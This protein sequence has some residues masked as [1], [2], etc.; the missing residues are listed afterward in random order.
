VNF[1][2]FSDT[3]FNRSKQKTEGGAEKTVLTPSGP[4]HCLIRVKT[5]KKKFRAIANQADSIGAFQSKFSSIIRKEL[6]G[7]KKK[8]KKKKKKPTDKKSGKKGNSS[9]AQHAPKQ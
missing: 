4:P 6:D 5:P 3:P 9:S 8:D 1:L 2:V 7:L